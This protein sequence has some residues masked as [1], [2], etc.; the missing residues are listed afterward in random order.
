LRILEEL[1]DLLG[2]EV[3]SN[4]ADMSAW[5]NIRSLEL[6]WLSFRAGLVDDGFTLTILFV[7]PHCCIVQCFLLLGLLSHLLHEHLVLDLLLVQHAVLGLLRLNLSLH[8]VHLLSLDSSLVRLR[9]LP[10]A[11]LLELAKATGLFALRGQVLEDRGV[12]VYMRG[13]FLVLGERQDGQRLGARRNVAGCGAQAA[14]AHHVEGAPRL[15]SPLLASV[16]G[17][18]PRSLGVRRASGS[19]VCRPHA[20]LRSASAR[21]AS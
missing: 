19:P 5:R 16:P 11:G 1:N 12:A 21:H 18:R 4:I 17:S 13:N 2:R 14:C 6:H 9:A 7:F 8:V 3:V 20:L 10:F 15:L